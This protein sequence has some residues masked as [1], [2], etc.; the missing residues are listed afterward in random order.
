MRQPNQ[1]VRRQMRDVFVLG[2]LLLLGFIVALVLYRSVGFAQILDTDLRSERQLA[3][4]LVVG[5]SLAAVLM[6][7]WVCVSLRRR[8]GDGRVA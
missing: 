5:L 6:A 8:K 3:I 2:G 4:S 1:E 7:S